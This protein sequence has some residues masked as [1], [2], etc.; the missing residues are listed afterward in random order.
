M[1]ITFF[2]YHIFWLGHQHYSAVWFWYVCIKYNALALRLNSCVHNLFCSWKNCL[3]LIFQN[4]NTLLSIIGYYIGSIQCIVFQVCTVSPFTF[5][6]N[7][8]ASM[9]H[10]LHWYWQERNNFKKI[11]IFYILFFNFD[12]LCLHIWWLIVICMYLFVEKLIKDNK[13]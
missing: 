3:S 8:K 4:K 10:F 13:V 6:E 5:K 2:I 12:L 9:N 1:K 7:Y 11:I